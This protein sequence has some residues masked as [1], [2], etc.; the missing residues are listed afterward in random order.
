MKEDSCKDEH[1]EQL[2]GEEGDNF[3][4]DFK[5]LKLKLDLSSSS[6]L[7]DSL[8]SSHVSF[9]QKKELDKKVNANYYIPVDFKLKKF[10]QRELSNKLKTTSHSQIRTR[11]ENSYEKLAKTFGF[12]FSLGNA[13][14]FE[15]PIVP[16]F[17][18]LEEFEGKAERPQLEDF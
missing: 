11:R 15:Q 2:D 6:F 13:H 14:S 17:P 16:N 8:S 7:Q 3:H 12:D 10:D 4:Y 5:N 1:R 18:I 9:L